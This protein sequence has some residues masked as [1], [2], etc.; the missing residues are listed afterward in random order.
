MNEKKDLKTI[1]IPR[2]L[3]CYRD[4]LLWKTYFEKLGYTCL[5]SQK[6]NRE[7][8]EKGTEYAVDEACLPLKMYLGHV[9]DLIGR[10]DAIFIP[11]EAGYS[12]IERACT[13]YSS[14]PDLC[15]N[16]FRQERIS[17]VSFSYDWYD[18][19][20][21]QEVYV[22]FG[23]MLGHSKKEA[24]KAYK[25]AKKFQDD[26]LK[27]QQKR[28]SELLAN[29]G[30]KVLMAGHPYVLHD[31]YIG[32]SLGQTLE[33]LGAKVLYT[34]Y[35]NRAEC[36]K[37]SYKFTET[38]PWLI[39]REIIGACMALKDRVDGIVIVSAYPCG[40]DALADDILMR[41]F[42]DIPILQL[43]I[44]AQNGTAGMETR[45]ES[46]VDIIRYQKAGGYAG[47]QN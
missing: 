32:A 2:G 20:N 18:K 41:S 15:A 1:G 24:K 14:L 4:G 45:L 5:I 21:E 40:P 13:R 10:C 12:N 47:I 29:D 35:E 16:I 33:E 34:D 42:H 39:N 36:L 46:F 19:T 9:R 3:M 26:F 25:E 17:I 38:M 27:R 23:Q 43:T 22:K 30:M 28:Q 6:S 8:L 31:P 37:R 44:D 11:R 7:V